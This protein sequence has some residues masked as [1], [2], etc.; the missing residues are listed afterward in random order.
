MSLAFESACWQAAQ[1][2]NMSPR[3]GWRSG[4]AAEWTDGHRSALL[5]CH[6]SGLTRSYIA[7]LGTTERV[8]SESVS[9]A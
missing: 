8:R 9:A 1:Q 2:C 3:T 5:L 4:V 7:K 6:R